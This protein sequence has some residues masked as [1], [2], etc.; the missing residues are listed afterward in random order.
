MGANSEHR[1]K[2]KNASR[3]MHSRVRS[4]VGDK[5]PE[6]RERMQRL[7]RSDV[8]GSRLAVME[9]S[10]LRKPLIS[11]VTWLWDVEGHG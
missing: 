6:R 2:P 10:C 5:Y 9:G 7:R 11:I 1:R 4:T 8:S 3:N